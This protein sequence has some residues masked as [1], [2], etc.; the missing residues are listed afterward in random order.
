MA[1]A[2]H[3]HVLLPSAHLEIPVGAIH[4]ATEV[5]G[6]PN[7]SDVN[8]QASDMIILNIYPPTTPGY[9]RNSL[10]DQLDRFSRTG[11]FGHDCYLPRI[12]PEHH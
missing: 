9:T 6:F 12:Y 2:L 10:F 4:A 1:D 8:L 7:I 11:R 5:E 3:G